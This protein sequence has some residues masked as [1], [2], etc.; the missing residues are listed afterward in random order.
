MQLK[1]NEI[2][3]HSYNWLNFFLKTDL[4]EYWQENGTTRTFVHYW[5]GCKI[6]TITSVNLLTV[7]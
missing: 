4:I 1:P 6:D 7:S 5:Q 3:L 2:P